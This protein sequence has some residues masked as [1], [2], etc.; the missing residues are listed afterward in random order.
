[1]DT[2]RAHQDNPTLP[3]GDP[4]PAEL[5]LSPR[6]FWSVGPDFDTVPEAPEVTPADVLEQLGPPPFPKT[7]FPFIGFLATIY[8]HVATHADLR[9]PG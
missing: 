1:M 7:G 5:P 9:N 8:E 4:P 2:E 6:L 3:G